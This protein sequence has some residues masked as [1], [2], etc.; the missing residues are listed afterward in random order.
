[1]DLKSADNMA[2]II[3][4]SSPKKITCL[5]KLSTGIAIRVDG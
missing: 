3:S 1:M 5:S 4:S 2:W